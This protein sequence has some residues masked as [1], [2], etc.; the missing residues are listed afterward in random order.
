M[1]MADS[2]TEFRGAF[3]TAAMSSAEGFLKR[4]VA[5]KTRAQAIEGLDGAVLWIDRA[6]RAIVDGEL[7]GGFA[8]PATRPPAPKLPLERLDI[9]DDGA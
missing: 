2:E 6:K 7:P 9:D 8:M 3:V 4:A 5:A 1:T